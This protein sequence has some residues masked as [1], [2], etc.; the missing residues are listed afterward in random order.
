MP[1]TLQ[2]LKGRSLT[3]EE[4]KKAAI[5]GWGVELLQAYFLVL[6]DIM[7]GSITRRSQPCWYKKQE[8]G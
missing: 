5:L 6:D 7:D 3:D 8:V 2:I 4:Y 1:D